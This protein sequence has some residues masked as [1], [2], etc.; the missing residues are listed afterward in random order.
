MKLQKYLFLVLALGTLTQCT[1]PDQIIDD[2]QVHLSPTF[3]KYVVEINLSDIT[4]P[5][6]EFD[7]PAEITVTGEDAEGIYNIDGTKNFA[8]NFGTVQL[9]V[10]RDFEPTEENPLNFRVNVKAD[11]YRETSVPV[12]IGPESYFVAKAADMLNLN[13]LPDGV[14]VIPPQKQAVDPAT[15]TLAT[16]MV[17]RAGT[18]DSASSIKLT[19]PGNVKFLDDN[20][21]VIKAKNGSGDL[22]VNVISY[23]DTTFAAQKAMPN[24]GSLIQRVEIDGE[25]LKGILSPTATFEINMTLNGTKVTGFSGATPSDGVKARINIPGHMINPVTEQ[26]YA[27]GDSIGLMSLSGGETAW[28]IEDQN[29]LVKNDPKSGKLYAE[30]TISHLSHVNP[31]PTGPVSGVPLKPMPFLSGIAAADGGSDAEESH[32]ITGYLTDAQGSSVSGKLRLREGGAYIT[33][34]GSFTNKGNPGNPLIT[35]SVPPPDISIHSHNFGPNFDLNI[36]KDSEGNFFVEIENT[37]KPLTVG[38]ELYCEGSNTVMTP[39]AGTKMFYRESNGN[40]QKWEHLYTFTQANQDKKRVAMPKLKD[41]L[42]YDFKA[43][44]G[45]HQKD[46]SDVLVRDGTIYRI[47]LPKAACNAV[48]L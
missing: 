12:E 46:T 48:G 5:D 20:G 35:L 13:D 47:T 10:A 38:Y 43:F 41:G 39:P 15:N 11:G 22:E 29:Y 44:V 6:D 37:Q 32:K 7:V 1:K 17:V 23:S 9:I 34:S 31:V 33:L 16:P 36:I 45:Q 14:G 8:V 18:K 26:P 19:I 27:A 42:K 21:Q 2:F 24:G 40:S 28:R 25:E 3:Y 30:P 4:H